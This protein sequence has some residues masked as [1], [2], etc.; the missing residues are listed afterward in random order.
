MVV[1]CGGIGM[2]VVQG[3]ALAGARMVIAVDIVDFKLEKAKEFGATHTINAKHQDVVQIVRDLTWSVGAD[4]AFEA[5]GTPATI[6]Q[7]YACTAKNG[8]AFALS[9]S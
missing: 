8:T 3:A 2:N 5:I 7:P 1:G 9:M 6:G 4:Y